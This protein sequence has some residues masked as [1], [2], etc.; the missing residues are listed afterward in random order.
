MTLKTQLIEN[1]T[2]KVC[3]RAAAATAVFGGGGNSEIC[4]TPMN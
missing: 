1:R 2:R 4:N 3:L